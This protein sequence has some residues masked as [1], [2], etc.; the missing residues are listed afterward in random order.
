MVSNILLSLTC[1]E[2]CSFHNFSLTR[3]G[4]VIDRCTLLVDHESKNRKNNK[5]GQET[6]EDVDHDEYHAIP[7]K[8]RF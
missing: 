6:G 7:L 3:A 2:K 1:V 5:T 4:N 8:K